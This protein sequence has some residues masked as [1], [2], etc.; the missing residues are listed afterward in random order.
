[1]ALFL[2]LLTILQETIGNACRA[3]NCCGAMLSSNLCGLKSSCD[4][5]FTP[6]CGC[7]WSLRVISSYFN[8]VLWTRCGKTVVL[9]FH[10]KDQLSEQHNSKSSKIKV[11]LQKQIKVFTNVFIVLRL[12]DIQDVKPLPWFF[13]FVSFLI[14]VSVFWHT[15]LIKI[16]IKNKDKGYLK[17]CNQLLNI[18]H[19]I[20]V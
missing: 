2:L 15:V 18:K 19:I 6:S 17:S 11:Y 10:G 8:D 1:M 14:K 3:S 13:F 7:L 5:C 9:N 4:C 16:R 12:R 20:S